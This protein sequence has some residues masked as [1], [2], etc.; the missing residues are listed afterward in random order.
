[1]TLHLSAVAAAAPQP[2]VGDAPLASSPLAAGTGANTLP[3]AS[4][5]ATRLV[6]EIANPVSGRHAA[7]ALPCQIDGLPASAAAQEAAPAAALAAGDSLAVAMLALGTVLAAV[8]VDVDL[9]AAA[10][11]VLEQYASGSSAVAQTGH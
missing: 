7:C 10:A 2:V 1:M 6:V 11:A 4:G 3:P 5:A 8:L 9:A